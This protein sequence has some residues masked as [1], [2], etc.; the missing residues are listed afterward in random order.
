MRKQISVVF[1]IFAMAAS[2]RVHGAEPHHADKGHDHSTPAETAFGRAADPVK[3][4]RTIVVEMRDSFEFSPSEITV[5][6]GEIVRFVAV[7]AGKLVHEMV[8]GTMKDL[9]E[10]KETMKQH[11][12]MHHDE[13]HMAHV[14]PGKSGVIVWQFTRPGEFYYACLVEDHFD[15]GMYGKIR[16]TG[17]PTSEGG[18]H[19]HG[20]HARGDEMQGMYG[21]YAMAR[22]SSGTAWQPDASP[23]QGIH[24]M[25][26]EW[27]TMAH[28]FVNLI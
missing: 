15:L 1:A 5:K 27:S 14:A 6:A 22:E 23:H 17:A 3:A 16:V 13:P 28:G 26:G 8:L 18:D 19:S 10:H 24:A 9:E 11:P 20:G 4:Q 7:N 25:Y 21:P 12:D 2:A